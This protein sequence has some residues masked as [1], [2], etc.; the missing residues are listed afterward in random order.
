LATMKDEKTNQLKMIE[1][2]TYYSK[3]YDAYR[4]LMQMITIIGI[5]ILVAIGLEYTPLKV[6][7]RPLV[8]IIVLIGSVLVIKRGINMFLRRTDNYDE[9]IWPMAPTTDT[10]LSTANNTQSFID[11]SGID[12]PFVCASSTCCNAGTVWSDASGCIVDPNTQS[13]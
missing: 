1:I 9:F 10:Q 5:C 4:R 12:V 2:T 11:I 6:V 7:S 8:I 13:T 3:Q